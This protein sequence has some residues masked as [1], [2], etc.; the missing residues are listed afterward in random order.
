MQDL[1]VV[2]PLLV[3]NLIRNVLYDQ[4]PDSMFDQLETYRKV[5]YEHIYIHYKQA[6]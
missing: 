4:I 5:I 1:K 6:A 3:D 2:F